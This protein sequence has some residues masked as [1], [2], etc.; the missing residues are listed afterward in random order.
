VVCVIHTTALPC[1][2]RLTRV[3]MSV[4]PW[5]VVSRLLPTLTCGHDGIALDRVILGARPS[6]GATSALLRFQQPGYRRLHRW[7]ASPSCAPIDPV[8]V[9]R[10]PCAWPFHVAPVWCVGLTEESCPT[11]G[12][13][14]GPALSIIHAPVLACDSVCGGVRLSGDCPAP[15][16]RLARVVQ[17]L[18]ESRAP[19]GGIVWAPATD[20]R[21]ERLHQARVRRLL[22]ARDG[23]PA[24]VHLPVESGW[25]GGHGGP[26]AL[27]TTATIPAGP[28]VPR[29]IWLDLEAQ[30]SNAWRLWPG[31]Q[32]RGEA[33]LARLQCE[34]SRVQPRGDLVL[35]TRDTRV[36][37]M[38]DH[39]SIGG[40]ADV[41]GRESAAA[42][43]GKPRADV[44]LQAV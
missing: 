11:M 5:P 13:L 42:T 12:R 44:G 3:T 19:D 24:G 26:E 34:A 22:V 7:V 23:L 30:A 36:V 17:L 33:G 32:R 39:E 10:T 31:L 2:G 35:A 28:G 15:Q 18:D 29:R 41:G 40:H 43:A 9:I 4:Q 6:T 20:L 8:A 37:L 14:Q 16:Q 21:S 38:E 27:E 1:L 25:A